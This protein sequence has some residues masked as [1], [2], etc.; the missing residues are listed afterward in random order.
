MFTTLM[1]CNDSDQYLQRLEASLPADELGAVLV[2]I[3]ELAMLRLT[4]DDFLQG[5]AERDF[6]LPRFLQTKQQHITIS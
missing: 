3:T 2:V 6:D 5:D 4:F 1:Q